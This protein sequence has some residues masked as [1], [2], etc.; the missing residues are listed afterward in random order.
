M[1]QVMT[2][3]YFADG[4]RVIE[5]QNE[6]HSGDLAKWLPGCK[7]GDMAASPLNPVVWHR[8]TEEMS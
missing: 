8:L 1:R 7:P 5:P 3:I 4:T 2:I 6:K